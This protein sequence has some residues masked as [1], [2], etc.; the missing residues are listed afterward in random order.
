MVT[1]H[2][3]RPDPRSNS[4][5]AMRLRSKTPKHDT[6]RLMEF[7]VTQEALMAV[8]QTTEPS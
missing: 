7:D 5:M 6:R 4:A 2:L 1:I 3:S 8:S